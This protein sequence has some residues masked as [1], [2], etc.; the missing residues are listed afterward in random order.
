MT[1]K[2]TTPAHE[3]ANDLLQEQ[4]ADLADLSR[5]QAEYAA[6]L[7]AFQEEWQGLLGPLEQ[8]VAAGDKQLIALMKRERRS[9]FA[10]GDLVRLPAGVLTR[11]VGLF[12]RKAKAVTPENLEAL[13]FGSAVKIVKSVDWDQ[14]AEWPEDRLVLV[15]TERAKKEVFS[16]ELKA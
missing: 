16:Y 3:Q 2:F 1:P 7:A 10:A 5:V 9:L 15:G 11:Q 4:A 13:G 6:A 8:E 14:L 12:V